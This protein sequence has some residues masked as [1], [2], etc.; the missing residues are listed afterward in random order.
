LR[1]L[2]IFRVL[3]AMERI[4]KVKEII[5]RLKKL[6]PDPKLELEF[7][8]P[9]QLLVMAILA[10]QES[11]KKVN[12]TAKELFAEL[13]E[14]HH[15]AVL[16]VD[17]LSE[18]IKHIRWNHHKAELI[19]KCCKALLE[20][21]D[22]KVPDNVDKLSKLPGVGRKTAHMVVGGAFKKPALITDRHFIRVA[23]RLGLT[24]E[25]K[26]QKVEKDIASWLPKEYWLE[27]SLLLIEHGKH[28]CKARNPL[29][30]KCPLTDLCECY[31]TTHCKEFKTKKT[32]KVA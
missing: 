12:K 10:A 25:T 4:D 17:E 16:E 20:L 1:E 7:E 14:P 11:D 27:L 24:K 26:P 19:I 23:N 21:H 13:K 6:Y 15:F 30:E 9:F 28:I 5:K 18:R 22:G 29:C 2:A 31:L 32:K 3:L 8:N